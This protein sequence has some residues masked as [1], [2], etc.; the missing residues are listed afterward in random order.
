MEITLNREINN[1]LELDIPINSHTEDKFGYSNFAQTFANLI[2][3]KT[4]LQGFVASINAPWGNGKTSCINLMKEEL[5]KHEDVAIIDFNPWFISDNQEDLIAKFFLSLKPFI[6]KFH[7]IKE[8][9]RKE[10]DGFMNLLSG[11]SLNLGF[12]NYDC[13]NLAKTFLEAKSIDTQKEEIEN[14][15][16][17]LNKKII[18]FID[19][20]DRLNH[21]EIL[22][23]FRLV[24]VIADFKSI[25]YVLAFDKDIVSSIL[26]EEQHI[27]GDKFLEKIIQLPLNLPIPQTASL[28]RYFLDKM[29][30]FISEKE[31]F[32]EDDREIFNDAY[33]KVIRPD[34]KN[35][36]TV[37]RLYNALLTTYPM[38][39]NDI[40]LT[41]FIII[42]FA[43]LF[44][45]KL[46]KSIALNQTLF[47]KLIRYEDK[48][49]YKAKLDAIFNSISTENQ[50]V[51]KTIAGIMFPNLANSLGYSKYGSTSVY[52]SDND[53]I[54]WEKQ[55]RVCSPNRIKFY[56]S[57]AIGE[58]D[59]SDIEIE[60]ILNKSATV[61]DIINIFNNYYSQFTTTKRTRLSYLIEKLWFYNN[62]I[63]ERGITNIF[64]EAIYQSMN[65][66]SNENDKI[67]DLLTTDNAMRFG[68]LLFRLYDINTPH[69]NYKVLLK[70]AKNP[71]NINTIC[72]EL[73]P[74]GQGLGYFT[75]KNRSESKYISDDDYRTIVDELLI[76]I[77]KRYQTIKNMAD[78]RDIIAFVKEF[79]DPFAKE[80]LQERLKTN[81]HFIE[82]LNLFY[83][84]GYSFGRSGYPKKEDYGISIKGLESYFDIQDIK[85]RLQNIIKNTKNTSVKD[86][87]EKLLKDITESKNKIR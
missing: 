56:F 61:K 47:T 82:F 10:I 85:K 87:S 48:D 81:K 14:F 49:A 40:N 31:E 37:N 22:Q 6:E 73:I 23:I 3:D 77:K 72:S 64:I 55:K 4:S 12:A 79:N 62:E 36:R 60:D 59:I 1:H 80:L 2:Y 51:Y 13:N 65:L 66:Y 69:E 16:T 24:K 7:R 19:D 58:E 17:K 20:I 86:K 74:L 30:T 68:R 84:S 35:I 78:V 11:F 53:F 71:K 28:E 39:K 8:I 18:V 46:W 9:K 32:S 43:R 25:T 38:I 45:N 33:Y 76:T 26:Q 21:R 15:L 63:N 34:I 50:E 29:N 67:I 27:D 42:E 70:I 57:L 83:T 75:E 54:K 5:S 52:F 44:Y 41:D